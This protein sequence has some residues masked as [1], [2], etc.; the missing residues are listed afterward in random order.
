[1]K[2]R[3]ICL[4]VILFSMLIAA[5]PTLAGVNVFAEGAYTD[6]DL[7]V[8]IYADTTIGSPSTLRSAGVKLTYNSSQLQVTGADKNEALWSLGGEEYMN[9][10]TS[11]S[12]EVVIILGKLDPDNTSAGVSGERVLLGK[13]TFAHA[14]LTSFALSLDYGKRGTTNEFKNF[15]DTATPDANVLDDTAVNFDTIIVAERGDADADGV[16]TTSDMLQTKELIK[17]NVYKCFADC[18]E[19][20]VLTTSDMLCI[21]PKI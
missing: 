9:P 20:G 2:K 7:V 13:V 8:Y 14:G 18:D 19:D 21:K 10:E 17:K 5:H 4:A 1:M 15:V 3:I 12:G 16:F 11:T 6:D